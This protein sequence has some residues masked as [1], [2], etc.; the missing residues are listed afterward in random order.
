MDLGTVFV[1]TFILVFIGEL[2]DKTQIAAGTGTLNNQKNG[3]LIFFSSVFALT[4][5]AGLTVF[6]AGLIPETLLPSIKNIGGILLVLYGIYL[7]KQAGSIDFD[8]TEEV[9]KQN[10]WGIFLSHF[11]VVFM[12]ELG[13]KT[14]FA[15]LAAAIENP[16]ALFIVFAASTL[17]L[18]TVTAGTVWSVTKLPSQWVKRVQQAGAL[19]MVI[20]GIYMLLSPTQ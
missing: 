4:T 7:Y 20:Y 5:V 14:Q 9:S 11:S 1:S 16:S 17:A 3:K 10:N 2:G 8:K 13:D 12:A 6:S 19:L 15:T 18:V